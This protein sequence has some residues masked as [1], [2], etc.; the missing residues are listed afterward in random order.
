MFSVNDF[1]RA[2]EQEFFGLKLNLLCYSAALDFGLVRIIISNNAQNFFPF[3][4]RFITLFDSTRDFF[5]IAVAQLT[6]SLYRSNKILLSKSDLY[7]RFCE[8]TY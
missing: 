5:A 2:L 3:L 6:L 7:R 4:S 8:L 1:H